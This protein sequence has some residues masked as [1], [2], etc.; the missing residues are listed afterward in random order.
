M[1]V[2]G[3]RGAG[4]SSSCVTNVTTMN[5]VATSTKVSMQCAPLVAE[6]GRKIDITYE[7]PPNSMKSEAF[8]FSTG[9]MLSGTAT[10]IFS[11]ASTTAIY[12][13]TCIDGFGARSVGQCRVMRAPSAIVFVA[14]PKSVGANQRASLGWVSAGMRSCALSSPQLS[15]FT[16]K[17][18]KNGSV[19]GAI[20]TPSLR[21]PTQFVLTCTT[22][23]GT[24]RNATAAV[25]VEI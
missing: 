6:K 12:Q 21:G 18:S 19:S 10:T 9:G 4:A 11:S 7:C 3:L 17:N 20:V 22:V 25:S 2:Y 1:T 16:V 15:D 8:G 14:N 13:L 23:S 24:T 5:A